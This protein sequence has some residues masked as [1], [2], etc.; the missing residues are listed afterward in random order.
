MVSSIV[1]AHATKLVF[2]LMNS[3]SEEVRRAN[4]TFSCVLFVCWNENREMY[5]KWPRTCVSAGL[6][7]CKMMYVRLP[8]LITLCPVDVCQ[9][10][11]ACI[12]LSGITWFWIG[13]GEKDHRSRYCVEFEFCVCAN[14][15][16]RSTFNKK[17]SP[18]SAYCIHYAQNKW[19]ETSFA[20][21]NRNIH[22]TR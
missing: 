7:R 1:T 2:A 18:L 6:I 20:M 9:A 15:Q 11:S 17:R 4:T 8:M 22:A 14:K 12:Y 5:T 10:R 3:W 19:I 13:F 21:L 16:Q